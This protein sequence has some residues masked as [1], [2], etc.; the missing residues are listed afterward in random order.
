MNQIK[1]GKKIKITTITVVALLISLLSG[2]MAVKKFPERL[3][4]MVSDYLYQDPGIIPD[5]IKIIAIDEETLGKLGPYSNWDRSYFAKL[6]EKLNADSEKAPRVIGIDVVFSGTDY[7]E[8]DSLLVEACKLSDNIV[9]ASTLNFDTKLHKK[10]DT[11]Y[12]EQFVSSEGRPY[13]ALSKVA[14]YGFTNAIFDDDGVIRSFYT[15]LMYSDMDTE[16]IKIYESFAYKIASRIDRIKAC[17]SEVE[18]AFVGKPGDFET[19]SMADVVEGKI[20]E[21]YFED[22]IVLVGAYE[23][24]ARDSYRVSIDPAEEM[25]GVE[26]Q[27]NYIYG[28]LNERIVYPLDGV[29]QFVLTFA[30]VFCVAWCILKFKLRFAVLLTCIAPVIYVIAACAL[31]KWRYHTLNILAVPLGIVLAFLSSA[32]LRYITMQKSRM[33]EM[34]S[35][36]FSMAEAMAEAI[37]GRTPYNA[38]HTKNVA[39]RCVEML[40]YINSQHKLKKTE[41][42]FTKE[43][44]LQLYLAAML[45][46]VGKMDV[47]LEIMDKPTKLG[48]REASLKSRLEII[49][50]RIENDVLSGHFNKEDAEKKLDTIDLFVKSLPA[51]NCGRPLNEAEWALVDEMADSIY[52]GRDGTQIP[53]L[54]EEEK[55]DL[56]IKAGTLSDKERNIMQSHVTYTDKILSHIQFG[57]H[58]DKVRSMASNHHELLNGRGYPAGIN[59]DELDVMTRILTIM[60]IYDSLIADD[61]PYKKAKPIPVA[62]N[63]LDEEAEAGKIDK[64]LLQYAKELYFKERTEE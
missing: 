25:F 3:E 9:L 54:S 49:K 62:F 39:L 50:L 14:D 29:W 57:E 26:L 5:N 8:E 58:F 30:V 4:Y 63:I 60:D 45:H 19:I 27:A 17:P 48:E 32:L 22:C 31:F 40:D 42:H 15:K 41:L 1:D 37:E 20:P 11:Y 64:E 55:A 13:D 18:V 47:P 56:H 33:L 21:G 61:R 53:Y 38:N 24:G 12:L 6:V 28:L 44:K 7:S 23:E 52:E 2:F 43:D 46:D 36:L 51:F 16:Q 59:A 10:N 35:M 34:Q